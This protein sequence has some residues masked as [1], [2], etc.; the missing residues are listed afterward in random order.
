MAKKT[1]KTAEKPLNTGQIW[2]YAKNAKYFGLPDLSPVALKQVRAEIARQERA[3]R[4]DDGVHAPVPVFLNEY[5]RG[6]Q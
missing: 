4:T 3:G 2:R 5:P 1:K 6:K